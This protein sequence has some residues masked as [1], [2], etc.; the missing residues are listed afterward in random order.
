MRTRLFRLHERLIT[1]L[2]TNDDYLVHSQTSL[3][4]NKADV[5]KQIV[6]LPRIFHFLGKVSI[7][8]R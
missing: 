2:I 5:A 8:A 4:F 1:Y 3:N 6:T 7:L